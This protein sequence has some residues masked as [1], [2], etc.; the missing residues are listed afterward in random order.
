MVE[1][2][3]RDSLLA[4]IEELKKSPWF[5]H[6]KDASDMTHNLYLERKDA[7]EIIVDLCIKKEPE[8]PACTGCQKEICKWRH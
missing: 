1:L 7:V 3:R 5:N 2:I 6:G 4:G 8:A